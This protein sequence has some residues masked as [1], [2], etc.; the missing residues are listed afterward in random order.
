MNKVISINEYP[1]ISYSEYKCS[2]CKNILP[3]N[4]F[5][6]SINAIKG[7]YSHCKNCRA[8]VHKD[9]QKTEK[10]KK[11]KLKKLY[12]L[13]PENFY[14]MVKSQN[15]FC[16]ICDNVLNPQIG[17]ICVDHCH[18]TGFVRGILCRRCNTGLGMF[19]DNIK[20]LKNA[21]IYLEKNMMV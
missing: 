4:M 14:N 15:G 7:H 13:T 1:R 11:A 12:G 18:I 6:K 16:K 5:S 9:Y 21:I 2:K 19:K 8:K 17:D 20:S 10:S 3:I